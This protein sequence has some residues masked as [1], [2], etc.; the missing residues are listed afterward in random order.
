MTS[1]S[2]GPGLERFHRYLRFLARLQLGHE[3]TALLDPDDLVQQTFLE[4]QKQW[5]AFQDRGEGELA[6]WL[7][8]I[9]AHN[10]ADALRTQAAA[11]RDVQRQRSLEAALE[12]TS[13]RLGGWL[14]A[15]QS[16]PSEQAQRHEDAVRLA[17]ALEQLPEAEREA[18]VLQH[19]QGWTL[20][21]IGERMGRSR[22]A[23][24]GLLKRGLKRLRQ[25]MHEAED[26]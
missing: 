19:W 12:Q 14:A 4:A 25:L 15:D 8:A 11:K 26:S 21:Q 7:R 5:P 10:L 6:A 2:A 23:V 20:A 16:S 1:D 18:L 22:D 17:D 24:A 9:L 13:S 3:G